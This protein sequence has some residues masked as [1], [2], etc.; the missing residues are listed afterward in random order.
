MVGGVLVP[1]AVVVLFDVVIFSMAMKRLPKKKAGEEDP[2]SDK[3]RK[4]EKAKKVFQ[5]IKARKGARAS[6]SEPDKASVNDGNQESDI[7]DD[8][9]HREK[10]LSRLQTA[11]SF[12]VL[13]GLSWVIGFL[14]VIQTP[15]DNNK[16][17]SYDMT[18]VA[19]SSLQGVF[20]LVSVY[21]RNPNARQNLRKLFCR[22]APDDNASAESTTGTD[23]YQPNQYDWTDGNLHINENAKYSMFYD[24]DLELQ[25]FKALPRI[26]SS[27]FSPDHHYPQIDYPYDNYDFQ[28][29]DIDGNGTELISSSRESNIR[30]SEVSFSEPFEEPFIIF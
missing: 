29:D 18:F 27:S 16:E 11:L 1:T 22:D 3:A 19:L 24:E 13:V 14:T 28:S 15:E 8:E 2:K 4:A 10:L 9:S 25:K 12:I 7:S 6:D 17:V 21:L 23:R 30:Y 20:L 5:K 26:K